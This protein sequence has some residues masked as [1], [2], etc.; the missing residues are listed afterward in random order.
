MRYLSRLVFALS[1]SVAALVPAN[2]QYYRDGYYPPP[3]RGYDPYDRPP[4]GYG[5]PPPGY[6]G[7]RSEYRGRFG[8]ICLTSR[9]SCFSRPAPLNSSCRCDIPGFGLKRGAIGQ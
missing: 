8:R 4:P 2:A 3:P 1:F 6:Y 7:G 9:G 5:R